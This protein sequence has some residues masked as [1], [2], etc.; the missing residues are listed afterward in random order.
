MKFSKKPMNQK[1][2]VVIDGADHVFSSEEASAEMVEAVVTWLKE[3]F[4]RIN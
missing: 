2:R 3:F 4:G 1:K